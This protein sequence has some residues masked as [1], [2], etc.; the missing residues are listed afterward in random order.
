M[1]SGTDTRPA[2]DPSPASAEVGGPYARY[3]LGVLVLVY[4][5]NFLDRQIVSIL[6][7]EIRRDLD[8]DDDQIGFLY[9]T[10]FAVFY[11]IFGIPLGRLA[12]VWNRRSL[13]AIGLAV[14][15]A[16][17][18]LSG[19]AQNFGQ[20]AAARIG[21][22]IGEASA[23]PAAFSLLS[24]WF[25]PARRATVL[26]IYSSGIYLGAGLGLGIG[27]LVV[28]AWNGAYADGTAP[29]GLRGWQVAYLVVG[30]PGLLMALW[31]RSLR[32]PVRGQAE[33][34]RSEPDP[35]PFRTFGRELVA[36]LPGATLVHLFNAGGVGVA[37][38][39]AAYAAAVGLGAWGLVQT[40][41]S[42]YQWV[43][44]GIGLYAAISWAQSLRLRDAVT[45]TLVFETPAMRWTGLGFAFLAF[46][47]YGIGFWTA[48]FIQRMHGVSIAETGLVLGGT[49][50][51]AG[52]LG[53]TLGGV[54]ADRMRQSHP[55]GRLRMG[56]LVA[57]L[58][59]PLGIWFLTTDSTATA[60]VLNFPLSVA[61]SM[62]IGAG[63]STVTDLV[64]P[65]MRGIAAAAYLLVI[66]FIGL[67]LGPYGI[68]RMSVATESLRTAMLLAFGANLVALACLIR[69]AHHLPRDEA[70]VAER[71]RA[72]ESE[73]S[74][75]PA[76]EL[77]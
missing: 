29:W 52:W 71:A 1:S 4:L 61:S 43:A 15:S 67:A 21:V 22:G 76:D 33:G 30:L 40:T 60:F 65:R 74:G 9:G 59:V 75:G 32:E 46:T 49:A 10:A 57:V 68:G 66:T 42:L 63:A 27:G 24:D 13:I 25:P 2:S 36:V 69:A 18:T 77:G 19:L 48:P 50:A 5:F 16:M 12:D 20:L 11:A 44:L 3:V 51:A 41:G 14:W 55:T 37:A 73:A 56:M 6:A 70:S 62:W 58:P 17:T 31:V 45:Y 8:I 28:D 64:L 34:I 26:A 39:N 53:V 23:T 38:R 47:G 7:E 35:H 54:L 72:A